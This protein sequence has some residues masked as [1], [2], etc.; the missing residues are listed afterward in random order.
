M[1][2]SL[3]LERASGTHNYSVQRKVEP[4]HL[5]VLCSVPVSQ[6][7]SNKFR[8]AALE[9]LCFISLWCLGAQRKG[10]VIIMKIQVYPKDLLEEAWQ[11]DKKLYADGDAIQPPKCLRCGAP[12]AAHLMANALSRYADV[13]ICE[14]CGMDEALRDTA[15]VPLPLT[16]WETVKSSRLPG[17]NKEDVCYLSTVC[18]FEEVFQHTDTSPTQAVKR[19]VNEIAYSRSD[20]D[21]C[22][23]STTWHNKWEEKPTSELVKEIDEFQAALF[24]LPDFKTLDTMKRFCRYAQATSEPTEFNLYSETEYLYIWIRLNT[25]FRDYNVYVHYYKK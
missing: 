6:A 15:H 20:Y 9:A 17:V 10:M 19:P 8:L 12:L 2:Y 25:R 4:T 1:P 18:T 14:A 24:K 11:I 3:V 21:G 22:R 7:H 16:E 13:Q 5:R 23:W